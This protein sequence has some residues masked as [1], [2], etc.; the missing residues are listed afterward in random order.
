MERS[1]LIDENLRNIE[2]EKKERDRLRLRE[3]TRDVSDSFALTEEAFQGKYWLCQ[4]LAWEL[5]NIL[6]PLMIPALRAPAVP[7]HLKVYY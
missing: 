7:I 2:E 6:C 3:L 1:N 4:D 5:I